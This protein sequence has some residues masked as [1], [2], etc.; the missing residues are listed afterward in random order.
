MIT[1][2]RFEVSPVVE[3][4]R[5]DATGRLYLVEKFRRKSFPRISSFKFDAQFLSL[6]ES[7]ID[8]IY[9]VDLLPWYRVFG[10]NSHLCWR[11]S[12]KLARRTCWVNHP[13]SPCDPYEVH[14]LGEFDLPRR[15][16]VSFEDRKLLVAPTVLGSPKRTWLVVLVS[17]VE[18]SSRPLGWPLAAINR[19]YKR[20]D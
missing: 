14:R 10:D 19:N 11:R 6:S 13:R 17:F 3:S 1:R 9:R 20:T 8:L 15:R 18:S 4:A 7:G 16:R 2:E 5:K 12:R